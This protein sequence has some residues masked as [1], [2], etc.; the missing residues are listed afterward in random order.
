MMVARL[1]LLAAALGSGAGCVVNNPP[2]NGT[3]TMQWTL[4]GATDPNLC[5]QSSASTF[6]LTVY[7]AGGGTAGDFRADCDAFTMTVQLAPGAYSAD[8][9]LLDASNGDRTTTIAVNP[10][11]IH[12]DVDLNVAVDFPAASFE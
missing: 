3:L 10:F 4:D 7:E 8:A 12:G 1:V 5:T 2:S 6:E 11:S 9:R